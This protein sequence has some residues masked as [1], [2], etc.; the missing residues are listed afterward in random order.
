M[1]LP[2]T[3]ADCRGDATRSPGGRRDAAATTTRTPAIGK[4][5]VMDDY[6]PISDH[7]LIGD[8]ETSALVATDGTIDWFCCPRFG[9]P[10]MFGS[11]LDRERGGYFR[12]TPDSPDHVSRQLY[13]PGTAILR[14]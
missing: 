9:S 10:S 5:G 8:L 12:V 6:T 2:V 7:G 11:I 4:G 1:P 3:A 13:L 14:T